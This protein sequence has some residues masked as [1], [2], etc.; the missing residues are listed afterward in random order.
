MKTRCAFIQYSPDKPDKF[1]IKNYM[2]VDSIAMY[3][4]DVFPYLGKD[5]DRP[6][7]VLYGEYVVRKIMDNYKN[8][9]LNVTTD[10][11]FTND[12]LGDYLVGNK[13][14]LVGTC[15]SNKKFIPS[16]CK[17]SKQLFESLIVY[18]Q[19]SSITSYQSKKNIC[20]YLYSTMHNKN[21]E[22]LNNNKHLPESIDYY[23]RH[24]HG[25]D[26]VDKMLKEHSVKA[27]S[28]RWSLSC[29]FNLYNMILLN[30]Y[31]MYVEV[32]QSRISRLNYLRQLVHELTGV[33]FSE[34]SENGLD[35]E[36]S[37]EPVNL[38]IDTRKK[39]SK[40]THCKSNVTNYLC[41]S[42]KK[43]VCGSCSF[44]LCVNCNEKISK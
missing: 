23:N 5:S 26:I 44:S 9:G 6:E 33:D 25:V 8:L 1:G 37:I 11:F 38:R 16:I 43:P 4:L 40:K 14:T 13:T 2:A 24:K 20:V 32:N 34:N 29:F 39:C 18:D 22:I 15:R 7:G 17:Q 21:V 35:N 19:N 10:R 12:T 41:V 28:R 30:G 27:A 36:S 3:I 31:R 42:C